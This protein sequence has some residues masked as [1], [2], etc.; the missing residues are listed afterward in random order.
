MC[1]LVGDNSVL[2][3]HTPIYTKHGGS[4]MALVLG[5][6]WFLDWGVRVAEEENIETIIIGG[7]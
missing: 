4:L 7:N 6:I 2:A 5:T 3:K 1:K